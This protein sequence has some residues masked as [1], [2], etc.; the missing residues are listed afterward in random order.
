MPQPFNSLAG[1]PTTHP[2]GESPYKATPVPDRTRL[3]THRN[4]PALRDILPAFRN[5]M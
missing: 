2:S 3:A 5:L 4:Y 1:R